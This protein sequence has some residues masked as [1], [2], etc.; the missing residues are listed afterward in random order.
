MVTCDVVA[1]KFVAG[2]PARVIDRDP[3]ENRTC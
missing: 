2:V 1:G 3:G